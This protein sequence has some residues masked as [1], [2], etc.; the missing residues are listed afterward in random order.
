VDNNIEVGVI[1]PHKVSQQDPA[2][3][4]RVVLV[5]TNI[6]LYS[7]TNVSLDYVYSNDV[8][9]T[10]KGGGKYRTCFSEEIRNN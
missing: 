7:I 5:L 2:E 3:F 1:S 10:S 4:T 8:N 6:G 9:L